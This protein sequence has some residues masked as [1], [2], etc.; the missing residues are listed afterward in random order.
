MPPSSVNSPIGQPFLVL[1]KV[2][3]TNNYAMGLV[4]AGLAK[5]GQACFAHHQFAG[6]GQRGK[7]WNSPEGENI[8]MSV[9]LDAKYPN[10]IYPLDR[11]SVV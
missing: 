9:V 1:D 6:K 2:D 8:T 7:E 5:H 10:N 11:K 3:S 4:H